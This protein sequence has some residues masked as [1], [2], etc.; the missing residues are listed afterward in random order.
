MLAADDLDAIVQCGTNMSMIDVAEKLEPIIEIPVLSINTT[1]FWYALR[2]NGFNEKI[3]N[4]G[5][6]FREF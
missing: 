6:I 2:E 1:L 3:K 4:V 5:R